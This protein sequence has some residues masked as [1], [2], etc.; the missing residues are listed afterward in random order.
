MLLDAICHANSPPSQL[1]QVSEAHLN[2]PKRG[3][4][5]FY[6]VLSKCGQTIYPGFCLYHTFK[7]RDGKTGVRVT[8]TPVSGPLFCKAGSTKRIPPDASRQSR[9]WVAT[10]HA[11]G[12]FK[13][14]P[15][16]CLVYVKPS[17]RGT[18]L[19]AAA[20]S[21][22]RSNVRNAI[23]SKPISHIQA[24]AEPIPSIT[25]RNSSPAIPA[26]RK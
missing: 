16:R 1:A 15:G 5:T 19:D 17:R 4:S 7:C 22:L 20:K 23:P 24:V 18:I 6:P 12:V 9:R 8:L 25:A 11:L 3:Q 2:A 26:D 13:A 21:T 10:D 14:R